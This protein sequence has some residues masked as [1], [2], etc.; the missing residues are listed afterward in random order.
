MR[1]SIW[2]VASILGASVANAQNL[3]QASS[4]WYQQAQE[5]LQERLANQ[6]NTKR[7]KNV[8][9]FVADGNGVGTNYA[10]R[11]FA[12]QQQGGLGDDYVQPFEAFPNVALIKT[13]STNGQTP[14]S[15]PTA[16]A[17]NSGIKT[18]ND[19]INVTEN[20]AVSDCAAGLENG[21]RT[22]AE[23]AAEQGKSV[24]VVSTARITHATPAAVY[25]RTANRDWEDNSDI[26][27]GCAQPDIA[28]QLLDQMKNGVVDVAMG[29]GRR[30]FLPQDATDAEGQPGRRTDGR[31]LVQEARD[32]GAQVVFASDDFA[33]LQASGNAPILGLFESSH[34][35]YEADRSGEPSLAEMTATTI[36]AL[37]A[38]DQG[39]YMMVEAGRVDH[40]NHGGNLYR[41][42]TDGKAFADAVASA[43]ELA[44]PVIVGRQ[45]AGFVDHVHQHLG[46]HGR[47]P[48]AGDGVFGQDLFTLG[49]R[50]HEL[51]IVIDHNA[52]G[53][54]NG[55]GLEV[56]GPHHGADAGTPGGTVHVVDDT[57]ELDALFAGHADGGD[58]DQRVGRPKGHVR[59][60]QGTVDKRR[61][62][63][64]ARPRW[65]SCQI[66][67]SR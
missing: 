14:D 52:L 37:S 18:K 38:N 31:D 67:Q 40:A 61:G 60:N 57:G 15:A 32:A 7:A 4:P 46:A 2:A 56:L 53:T 41:T 42:V 19:L 22:F 48:L 35:Q 26:P 63:F 54:A 58:A 51:S 39:F 50:L 30:H 65:V 20:V 33:A 12:G 6:P 27:E 55:D 11:L 17:M 10:S 59:Y 3:P 13:Y 64:F 8:I 47:Q 24:G 29:G 25:A 21:V 45:R 5:A 62:I 43:I 23:I 9:L 49:H 36:N 34:M 66:I 1:G 44:I 16:S 28:V